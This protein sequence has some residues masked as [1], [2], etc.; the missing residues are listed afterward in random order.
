MN[1]NRYLQPLFNRSETDLDRFINSAIMAGRRLFCGC[2]TDL[3]CACL[4]IRKTCLGLARCYDSRYRIIAAGHPPGHELYR[5]DSIT[6]EFLHKQD[7]S[8]RQS[9]KHTV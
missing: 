3:I 9:A 8:G 6:R 7:L 4:K 1:Q 5:M 2:I